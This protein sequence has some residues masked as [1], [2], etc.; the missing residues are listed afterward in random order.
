MGN[1]K[2]QFD[3]ELN[4]ARVIAGGNHSTKVAGVPDSASG[5]RIN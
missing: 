3:S 1:S 4:Q 2:I 5:V